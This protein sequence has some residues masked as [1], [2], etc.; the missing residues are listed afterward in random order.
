MSFFFQLSLFLDLGFGFLSNYSLGGPAHNTSIWH[1]V[2]YHTIRI[3]LPGGSTKYIL[4]LLPLIL[5]L[6]T[7]LQSYHVNMSYGGA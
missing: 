5:S 1:C 7:K 2:S 4:F 3:L 6:V